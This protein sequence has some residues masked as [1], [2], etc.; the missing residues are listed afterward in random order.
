MD[1]APLALF[2]IRQ[3]TAILD[4]HHHD[5]MTWSPLCTLLSI[6]WK[7][8]YLGKASL[9]SLVKFTRT[10]F[11]EWSEWL[12]LRPSVRVYPNPL[13][14]LSNI[15][16]PLA[17]TTNQTTTSYAPPLESVHC[18][19]CSQIH[20]P[21]HHWSGTVRLS[22]AYRQ[23]EVHLSNNSLK[24]NWCCCNSFHHLTPSTM[25][26]DLD[27]MNVQCPWRNFDLYSLAL[28]VDMVRTCEWAAF[29]KFR[30]TTHV[31]LKTGC[32]SNCINGHLFIVL[33][34]YLIF[35]VRWCACRM[36]VELSCSTQIFH[37]SLWLPWGPKTS[38][39]HKLTS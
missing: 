10:K 39:H 29:S 36:R 30:A 8:A 2:I 14:S 18:H 1:L 15:Y 19:R 37:L 11:W 6:R 25:G 33:W 34:A 24:I 22:A 13:S 7:G 5:T 35:V 31:N 20:R 27:Y 9:S 32:I 3:S 28:F 38:S 12:R 23:F 26:R 17:F 4:W 21:M 16:G